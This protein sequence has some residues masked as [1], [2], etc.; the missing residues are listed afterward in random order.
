MQLSTLS[1]DMGGRGHHSGFLV[2]GILVPL[3]IVGLIAYGIWQLVSSR[4]VVPARPPA[5]FAP[6]STALAVLDERFARGEID[7]DEFVQRRTLL[8]YP[9]PPPVP[10]TTT[11]EP[12]QN[13]TAEQ[14]AT[15]DPEAPT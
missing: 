5:G 4:R 11:P 13:E 6:S 12:S 8:T 2:F 10:P 1:A 15:T 14:P 3:V 9:A 7:A